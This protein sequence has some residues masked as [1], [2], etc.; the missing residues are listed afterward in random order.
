[1]N[2]S[3]L[4]GPHSNVYLTSPNLATLQPSDCSPDVLLVT[5]SCSLDVSETRTVFERDLLRRVYNCVNDGG[6]VLIPIYHSTFFHY[7]LALVVDYCKR[8][9]LTIPIYCTTLAELPQVFA[10]VKQN[11]DAS[12]VKAFDEAILNEPTVSPFIVFSCPGIISE[13]KNAKLFKY[14]TTK[15]GN[16]LVLSEYCIE[17]TLNYDILYGTSRNRLSRLLEKEQLKCNVHQVPCG[18]Q[19]DARSIAV[20]AKNLRPK[21]LMVT[22]TEDKGRMELIQQLVQEKIGIPCHF[23]LHFGGTVSAYLNLPIPISMSFDMIAQMNEMKTSDEISEIHG[24]LLCAPDRPLLLLTGNQCKQLVD[25][26]QHEIFIELT[27]QNQR[28]KRRTSGALSF[29]LSGGGASAPVQDPNDETTDVPIE[30]AVITETFERLVSELKRWL[31]TETIHVQDG[32]IRVR[33][34]QLSITDDLNLWTSYSTRDQELAT[35]LLGICNRVLAEKQ[36][37]LE[38]EEAAPSSSGKRAIW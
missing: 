35:R 16:L 27:G 21:H 15:P 31:T 10:S 26:P 3:D 20:L 7:L 9:R 30:P 28:K 13:K 25:L 33:T 37:S 29:V 22:G 23:L 12:R 18:D 34:V 24:V 14:V 1:M 11:H 6:Q 19:T 17:K 32:K 4:N 5:A 8:L 2:D 36:N 38:P